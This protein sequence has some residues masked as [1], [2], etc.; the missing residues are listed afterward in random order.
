MSVS[1]SEMERLLAAAA[2]SRAAGNSW[3]VVAAKLNRSPA[4]C[5]NWP[6]KHRV[7][8]DALY[9]AAER[10]KVA[11]ARA[12]ATNVLRKQLRLENT[13]ETR[14]AAKALLT[15]AARA[16]DPTSKPDAA[17]PEALVESTP[18]SQVPSLSDAC[19]ETLKTQ[20]AG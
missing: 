3:E 20:S 7:Q 19:Q 13:K 8:W 2:E 14:D 4:T 16:R 15:F 9:A 12:E 11:E 5:R 18:D 10:Q 6:A 1:N 17:S